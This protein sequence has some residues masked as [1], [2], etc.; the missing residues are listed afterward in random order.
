MIFFSQGD[1]SIGV[2]NVQVVSVEGNVNLFYVQ[3]MHTRD[4][5]SSV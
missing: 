4:N 3:C 5:Y 1:G 2:N